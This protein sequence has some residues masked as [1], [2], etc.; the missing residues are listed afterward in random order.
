MKA[1]AK[2]HIQRKTPKK[3]NA[4]LNTIWKIYRKENEKF[5][6]TKGKFSSSHENMN[7]DL[8]KY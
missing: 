1:K 5:E 6:E 8:S 7:V 3:Y 2:H 4:A